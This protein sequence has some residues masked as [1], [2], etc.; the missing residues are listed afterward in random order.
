M[1]HPYVRDVFES[2]PYFQRIIPMKYFMK[3]NA[4]L[5]SVRNRGVG[6]LKALYYYPLPFLKLALR[7]YDVA[8]VYALSP[9]MEHLGSAVAYALGIPFR[10]G[11]GSNREN[12]LHCSLTFDHYR[13]HRVDLYIEL[14]R[15]LGVSMQGGTPHRYVFPLSSRDQEWAR[16]YLTRSGDPQPP[17]MAIHPGGAKLVVPRRWPAHHF[18]RVAQWFIRATG[19]TVVLTGGKDDEAFCNRLASDLGKGVVN[20]CGRLSV[21]E[22]AAVLGR[23]D[24][25][26][27]NDTSA[28]HLAAAVDLPHIVVIFGP[29]DPH[30]LV[31]KGHNIQYLQASLPCVPCAGS[32]IG[33]DTQKCSQAIEGECLRAVKPEQVIGVLEGVLDD[34]LPKQAS[35]LGAL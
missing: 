7:G 27:T 29:T 20:T 1:T 35:V 21:R 5:R 10:V 30:L 32:V 24:I 34:S 14:L 9:D 13:Q 19:G 28:M 2:H 15:F 12:F 33:R 31:P 8:I 25:C 6:V 4:S 3:G 23:C 17:L 26:L 16:E 18:L 11:F 22:T